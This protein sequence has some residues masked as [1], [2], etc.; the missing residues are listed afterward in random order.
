MSIITCVDSVTNKEIAPP[1]P[2]GTTAAL[3]TIFPSKEFRIDTFGLAVPAGQA[4]RYCSMPVGTTVILS[5][6]AL[7]FD[8]IPQPLCAIGTSRCWPPV[9]AG[10]PNA[11]IKPYSGRV[12]ITRQGVTAISG[13][14]P[15]M[16]APR[17]ALAGSRAVSLTQYSGA[18]QSRKT[19]DC[20]AASGERRMHANASTLPVRKTR[21]VF[22]NLT[23]F[24]SFGKQTK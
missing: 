1:V 12:S 9:N 8:G 7:A 5:E 15:V 21:T 10:A 4:V 17:S 22:V 20:P 13:I 3:A 19:M 24:L 2:A 16:A 6:Y 11:P 18:A 14:G 23:Y